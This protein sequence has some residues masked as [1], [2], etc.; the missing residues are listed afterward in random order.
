MLPDDTEWEA[1]DGNTPV[2]NDYLNVLS[3]S[4]DYRAASDAQGTYPAP[5]GTTLAWG[6]AKIILYDGRV[7]GIANGTDGVIDD[8]IDYRNRYIHVLAAHVVNAGNKATLPGGGSEPAAQP[9]GND[10]AVV[11]TGPA[12]LE[13][14]GATAGTPPANCTYLAITANSY[15]HVDDNNDLVWQNNEGAVIH[16]F[17]VLVV[18]DQFPTRP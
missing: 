4:L 12:F 1:Y 7:A 10:Y 3:R 14:T 8:T 13:R 2:P 15:I 16:P 6:G 18:T 17:I 9:V 5:T 11:N